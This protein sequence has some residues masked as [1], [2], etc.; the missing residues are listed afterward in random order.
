MSC[1]GPRASKPKVKLEGWP[2][3]RAAKAETVWPRA[4]PKSELATWAAL[5]FASG[6]SPL[7]SSKT[8]SIPGAVT[9]CSQEGAIRKNGRRSRMT[10]AKNMGCS[11]MLPSNCLT[12]LIVC[13][14]RSAPSRFPTRTKGH[15]RPQQSSADLPVSAARQARRPEGGKKWLPEQDSNLRP[16]D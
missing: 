11:F 16:D 2:P 7:E 13:L 10:P 3:A 5:S 12:L 14:T 4:M 9:D 1:G 8:S 15:G 6:R